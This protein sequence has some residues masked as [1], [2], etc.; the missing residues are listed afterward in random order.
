MPRRLG[1]DAVVREAA[2]PPR[3]TWGLTAA[4][5]AW[6]RANGDGAPVSPSNAIRRPLPREPYLSAAGAGVGCGNVGACRLPPVVGGGLVAR[7]TS[8]QPSLALRLFLRVLCR[9]DLGD[10]RCC[11]D[12]SPGTTSTTRARGP[13]RT[14]SFGGKQCWGNWGHH[15]PTGRRPVRDTAGIDDTPTRGAHPEETLQP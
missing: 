4:M 10:R 11:G 15:W 1:L 3:Q 2:R 7:S 13:V 6:W 12:R 5:V 14:G 9:A 8:S